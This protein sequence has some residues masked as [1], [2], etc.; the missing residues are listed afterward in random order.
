MEAE[1][2]S[3]MRAVALI[4]KSASEDPRC[5]MWWLE[6]KFPQTW[7]RKNRHE[8]TGKNGGPIAHQVEEQLPA[9]LL[10]NDEVRE[11]L[12]AAAAA[13]QRLLA[14]PALLPKKPSS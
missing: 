10:A 14:V 1:K 7:G 4:M 6:R 5:A 9:E 11:L 8:L 3:E 12:D 13:A 2:A